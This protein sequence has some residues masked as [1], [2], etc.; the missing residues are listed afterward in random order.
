MSLSGIG[1]A[2][3]VERQQDLRTNHEDG[4][5]TFAKVTPREKIYDE[6]EESKKIKAVAVCLVEES[7][8]GK[9]T[10]A[11]PAAN[12]LLAKVS[13]RAISGSK[14][15]E[16]L[17]SSWA[18]PTRRG[19]NKRQKSVRKIAKRATKRCARFYS[20]CLDERQ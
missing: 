15:P 4:P 14:T 13:E 16:G 8:E 6:Q 18:T 2:Q 12:S 20:F 7:V 11:E 9:I 1:S 5:R 19:H 3:P 10:H 17:V